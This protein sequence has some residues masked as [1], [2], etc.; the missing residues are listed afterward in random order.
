M[1]RSFSARSIPKHEKSP[2]VIKRHKPGKMCRGGRIPAAIAV[3]SQSEGSRPGTPQTRIATAA[4]R[5]A[6]HAR[7]TLPRPNRPS[8][9][10]LSRMVTFPFFSK[11][12]P[13]HC[14]RA[15]FCFMTPAPFRLSCDA[16]QAPPFQEASASRNS[17]QEHHT[18]QPSMA[19]PEA[20]KCH[21]HRSCRKPRR[22]CHR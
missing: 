9:L 15:Y 14:G 7:S 2:P 10:P 21:Q 18:T 20:R 17:A 11:N 1:V 12:P 5:P 16:T 19:L 4:N 8:V 3:S 22:N 6:T 13:A